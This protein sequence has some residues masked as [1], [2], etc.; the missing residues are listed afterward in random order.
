MSRQGWLGDGHC[1]YGTKRAIRK[2]VL[3]LAL[4]GSDSSWFFLHV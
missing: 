2:M 1:R 4:K 3:L